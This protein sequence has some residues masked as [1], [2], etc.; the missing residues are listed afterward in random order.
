M[1]SETV[2]ELT[3]EMLSRRVPPPPVKPVVARPRIIVPPGVGQAT[4][5]FLNA[6]IEQTGLGETGNDLLPEGAF[7]VRRRGSVVRSSGGDWVF[8]AHPDREGAAE[9]AMVLL[10]S[11]GLAQIEDDLAGAG[12]R[13]V[14]VMTGQVMQYR[15]Q[16][17]LLPVAFSIF[18]ADE[19]PKPAADSVAEA[20]ASPGE[21]DESTGLD[22]ARANERAEGPDAATA[23]TSDTTPRPTAE[24]QGGPASTEA[25][26]RELESRRGQPRSISRP[27]PPARP[28]PTP[29]DGPAS[30]SD[31]GALNSA[32]GEHGD[33]LRAAAEFA[34]SVLLLSDRRARVT[35]LSDGRFALVF[36][37]SFQRGPEATM[38]L[39]EC[40]TLQ[41][42]EAYAYNRDDDGAF[43]V[44]GRAIP[45]R[46]RHYFLPMS[47]QIAPTTDVR[48]LH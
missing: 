26:I 46:G 30:G 33:E 34:S 21:I 6:D 7:L 18:S 44:T 1:N 23:G 24:A 31:R 15:D 25:I 19:L 47:F 13:P 2:D 10:P 11:P 32:A 12:P 45:Y 9:R 40:S 29:S 48:S 20:N 3:L 36:D 8:L 14:C 16:N 42:L 43:T 27:T 5:P 35:R 37:Q 22:Y 17:Y 28:G 39:L 38:P 41:R 4:N